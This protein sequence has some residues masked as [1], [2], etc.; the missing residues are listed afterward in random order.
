MAV[1]RRAVRAGARVLVC[2]VVLAG[3]GG[4]A[5]SR[6]DA[7]AD[8][9]ASA[10]AA[11]ASSTS[12][13]TPDAGTAAATGENAVGTTAPAPPAPPPGT[14]ASPRKRGLIVWLLGLGPDAPTGPAEFESF[15]ALQRG[16]CGPEFRQHED[17][18]DQVTRGVFTGAL[19]ACRAALRGE[20][21][22]WPAAAAELERARGQR[23][24]LSCL[25][26]AALDL[27][28]RLVQAHRSEPE[29]ALE[30]AP[31]SQAAA[32]PC[33][34]VERVEPAT[35]KPGEKVRLIGRE[36][37]PKVAV[38]IHQP[39]GN[40]DDAGFDSR[41]GELAVPD[42]AV[43]TEVCIVVVAQ[44]DWRAAGATLIVD[45]GDGVTAAPWTGP[46]PAPA[47]P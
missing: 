7:D 24:S 10:A 41:T 43:S 30:R 12:A 25:G 32:A 21:Q 15:A 18:A 11:T 28:D 26:Q 17:L 23:G 44:P 20:P 35:A 47:E 6:T 2:A 9:V 37:G 39:N 4:G 5:G 1:R 22:H 36:L 27:L 42:L 45:A 16:E 40:V 14:A 31:Q 46:C 33:P 3:C 29:A 13:S 8:A 38:E 34:V 19:L